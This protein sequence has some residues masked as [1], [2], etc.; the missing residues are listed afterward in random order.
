MAHRY[1]GRRFEFC[2]NQAYAGID[3]AAGAEGATNSAQDLKEF[4]V[5]RFRMGRQHSQRL[6][7]AA[8]G[9]AQVMDD[10][11]IIAY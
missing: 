11:R 3:I 4:S 2:L 5:D 6:L 10:F 1:R 9:D 8:A 7:E